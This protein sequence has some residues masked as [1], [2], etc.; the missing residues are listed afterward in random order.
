MTREGCGSGTR[1]AFLAKGVNGFPSFQPSRSLFYVSSSVGDKLPGKRGLL[2]VCGVSG[3][4]WSVG[5]ERGVI[6]PNSGK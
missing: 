6:F 1:E 5:I 4:G 3:V 2:G